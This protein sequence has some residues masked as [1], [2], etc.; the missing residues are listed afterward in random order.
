MNPRSPADPGDWHFLPK[1]IQPRAPR[2]G[3]QK[4]SNKQH[5]EINREHDGTLIPTPDFWNVLPFMTWSPFEQKRYLFCGSFVFFSSLHFECWSRELMLSDVAT[6]WWI[7]H[8]KPH[9]EQVFSRSARFPENISQFR[10]HKI[11]FWYSQLSEC[12]A[13]C[14][15]F[16]L[17]EFAS[18]KTDRALPTV[19]CLLTFFRFTTFMTLNLIIFNSIFAFS[20]A[21]SNICHN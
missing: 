4:N 11:D 8:M 19:P 9:R 14:W 3:A 7:V 15:W 20:F 2:A 16:P 17:S 18:R 6:T 1:Y 12:V 21:I 10:R 5:N 13:L